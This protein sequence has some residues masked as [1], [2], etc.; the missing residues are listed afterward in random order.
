MT[1]FNRVQPPLT[2]RGKI[3]NVLEN[4]QE[5]WEDYFYHPVISRPWNK[6]YYGIAYR[7]FD[8][9]HVVKTDLE[10]RYYDKDTILLHS[11]FAILTDFVEV[12]C[13]WM[14]MIAEERKK[15]FFKQHPRY[16]LPRP[17]CYLFRF[18]DR[19]R[20]LKF[21]DWHATLD[22]SE[23]EKENMGFDDEQKYQEY[24][25]E[26]RKPWQEIKEL[27]LWWKDVYPNR[28][29]P[30]DASGWTAWCRKMEEKGQGL[31][32]RSVPCSWDEDG[33]PTMYE[34][35]DLE[36]PEEKK[37]SRR[38]LDDCRRIEQ[39]QDD[40]ETEMLCRLAKVRKSLWT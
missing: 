38:I 31:L 28:P 34:L 27:Y 17:F 39:E 30:M 35:V 19:E 18:D 25:K 9:Y 13:S 15:P 10:P 29:C 22:Y 23:E 5:A 8:K 37:E 6:L 11:N 1:K 24:I 36:T 40:E 7:T 2:L 12:E 21:I 4:I 32:H 20:G 14:E 26:Y 16:S 3:L 33:R